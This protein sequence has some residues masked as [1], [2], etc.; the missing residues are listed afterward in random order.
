MDLYNIILT[1]TIFVYFVWF[2]V[3]DFPQMAEQVLI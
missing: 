3:E 1:S 2:V